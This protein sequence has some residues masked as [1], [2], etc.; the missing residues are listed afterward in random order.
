MEPYISPLQFK[1]EPSHTIV[2]CCSD[3]RTREQVVDFLD[4]LG[5]D[6]DIY[7]VPGGPLVFGGGVEVFQDASIGRRRIDYLIREHGAQK[8]ILITHGSEDETCQCGMAKML[9]PNDAPAERVKKQ[10]ASL[11]T[12]A[13]KVAAFANLPVESYFANVVDDMVQFEKME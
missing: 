8:V 11:V 2:I 10:L 13:R 9:F 4:H 3:G 7:A 6:A 1:E 5:I 12:A